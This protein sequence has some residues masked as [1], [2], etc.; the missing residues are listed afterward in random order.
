MPGTL[1]IHEFLQRA[2]VPYK[3][4]PHTAAFTA[5]EEAAATHIP[6]RDWAKVVACFVDGEPIEAVIPAPMTVNLDRLREL[7]RG[8]DIRLATEDELRR[9]FPG[10]EL[11]AMPPLGPLYGYP[12]FV[13]VALAAELDIVFSAGT[14][15]EAISMTWADYA[16]T[17]RPIVGRFADASHDQVGVFRLSYRE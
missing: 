7:A 14:H 6:G 9:L 17:V 13:D 4:V 1:S 10:C 5:Q 8:R 2:D 3:V 12:V 16:A 11:G 15:T